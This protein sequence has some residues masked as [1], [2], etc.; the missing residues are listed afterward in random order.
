MPALGN[1]HECI[2]CEAKF[3]DLGKSQA[4]CPS[5]GTDQS[6][7]DQAV[8]EPVA[9]GKRKTRKKTRKKKASAETA[10]PAAEPAA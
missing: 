7:T 10:E 2:Q 4:I 6:E 1:K 3:Y 5:C 9:A 8:D